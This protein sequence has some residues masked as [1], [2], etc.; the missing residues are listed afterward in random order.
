MSNLNLECLPNEILE[1][2]FKRL[3]ITDVLFSVK[4]TNK[5]F[6]DIV[7]QEIRSVTIK[8]SEIALMSPIQRQNYFGSLNP[9]IVNVVL[10]KNFDSMNI[11]CLLEYH[12]NAN[13]S[14][15]CVS[16][17]FPKDF[18]VLS[19]HSSSYDE[20]LPQKHLSQMVSDIAQFTGESLE[21]IILDIHDCHPK[22]IVENLDHFVIYG[23]KCDVHIKLA[24]Y[25]EE[26]WMDLEEISYLT[27]ATVY[28]GTE[29]QTMKDAIKEDASK[30]AYLM[31]KLKHLT[32]EV[33]DKRAE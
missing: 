22:K 11:T 7:N 13:G 32:V 20:D 19:G 5:R 24:F 6:H 17:V 8:E 9:D 29:D 33:N 16:L 27:S 14:V 12:L 18:E 4:L 3:P 23:K 25:G 10:D 30:Q 26:T 1:L 21:V 15:K 28:I 31:R 2:I